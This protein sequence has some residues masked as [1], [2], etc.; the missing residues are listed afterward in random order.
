LGRESS[1]DDIG[2]GRVP[3]L[4]SFGSW[5]DRR[6]FGSRS[7]ARRFHPAISQISL[8]G[9]GGGRSPAARM[10]MVS[11]TVLAVAPGVS[12][13]AAGLRCCRLRWGGD[14]LGTYCA[15]SATSPRIR[16]GTSACKAA[17]QLPR[18]LPLPR[19]RWCI[20]PCPRDLISLRRLSCAQAR[21][22]HPAR[23]EAPHLT[24][25][26]PPSTW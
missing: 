8:V 6:R 5:A 10:N 23:L 17:P 7:A 22:E 20:L 25:G 12:W 1:G 14:K 13:A 3:D 18:Q 4:T 24:A 21:Q 19:C 11:G 15:P 2:L 9:D 16:R 26:W